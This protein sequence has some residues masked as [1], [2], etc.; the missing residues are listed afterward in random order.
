M[1][2]KWIIIGSSVTGKKNIQN[3][4]PCQDSSRYAAISDK[5]NII[6]VADGAGSLANS[7]L[8]SDFITAGIIRLFQ[9]QSN[10]LDKINPE[11]WEKTIISILKEVNQNLLDYSKSIEIPYKSLGATCIISLFSDNELYVA[12]IGDGRA[13]Y[14]A[15][16]K[17][18]EPSITPFQGEYAGETI[19]ITSD[20]WDDPS[21]YIKTDSFILELDSV[22]LL[23]DGSESFSWETQKFDQKINKVVEI[24]KPF[25]PF[26][27]ENINAFKSLLNNGNPIKSINQ[28]WEKYLKIGNDFIEKEIDDKTLVIAFRIDTNE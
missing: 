11:N 21:K 7:H 22:A 12:H 14:K 5:W 25:S 10:V 28:K 6:V 26:F 15:K 9:K 17:E 24:N 4:I 19:F 18:W 16:D 8:G 13:G 2:H 20:I 23:T 1:M 3:D 27:N